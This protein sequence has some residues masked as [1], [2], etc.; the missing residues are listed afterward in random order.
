MTV[1][2][3]RRDSMKRGK[4]LIAVGLEETYCGSWVSWVFAEIDRIDYIDKHTRA[5][6]RRRSLFFL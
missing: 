1:L 6:G 3:R 5:S 2:Q 4:K